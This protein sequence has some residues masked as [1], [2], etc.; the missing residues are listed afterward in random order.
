MAVVVVNQG[1]RI[2]GVFG[3]K[4]EGIGEREVAG[5]ENHFTERGVFVMS[6]DGSVGG[7]NKFGDV[8]VA[9]NG[10]KHRRGV[11]V[12]ED[13]RSG[14]DWFGWIPGEAVGGGGAVRAPAAAGNAKVVVV[15]EAV[16]V[17]GRA[18]GG[19]LKIHS[20]TSLVVEGH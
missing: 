4:S 20:S 17:V 13:E 12:I 8:F 11:G 16:K 1:K 5:G 9:I 3:R 18:V 19:G 14:G 2:I 6:G 10:I 7:G 15:C